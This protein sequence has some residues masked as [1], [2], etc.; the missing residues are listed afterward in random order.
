MAEHSGYFNVYLSVLILGLNW[1]MELHVYNYLE[2]PIYT[3]H[4]QH[5]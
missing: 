4:R 5:C 1:F 3:R 2:V